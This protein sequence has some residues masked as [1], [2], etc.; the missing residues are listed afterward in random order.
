MYSEARKETVMGSA[1]AL[2]ASVGE[3]ASV[4]VPVSRSKARSETVARRAW[5]RSVVLRSRPM[6]SEQGRAA[7]T[8]GSAAVK[9]PH[10]Q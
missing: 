2:S 8:T 3:T 5:R 7:E 4:K 1:S 10:P 6:A 9:T